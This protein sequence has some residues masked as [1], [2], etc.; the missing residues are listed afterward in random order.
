MARRMDPNEQTIVERLKVTAV[1]LAGGRGSRLGGLFPDLPKPLIP[2]GD[3]PFLYWV[4]SW[5]VGQGVTDVIYA[6]GFRA[7]K[8]AQWVETVRPR[9]EISLRYMSEEEP[10][11]TGGGLLRC[12]DQS[13]EIVLAVNGDSLVLTGL[14]PAFARLDQEG[15]DAI[16]VGVSVDDSHRYGSLEVTR[17][18]LL[19]G[20][21]EKQ[22]GRGLV[23]GGIYLFR[24]AALAGFPRDR[25]LSLEVDIL[26]QLLVS[27]ARIGVFDV[28]TAPFLDI[29]TPET[30]G[31]ATAFVLSH[32]AFFPAITPAGQPRSPRP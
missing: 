25:A 16:I 2:A 19:R 28:G 29:G 9:A 7:D 31:D 12:L 13:R 15:L 1:I 4:T 24:R 23:N 5:L 3:R 17:Q 26:P 11:G 30:V 22:P 14:A 8:I 27:G 32:P 20:F 10:R 21:R 6:T 18:G